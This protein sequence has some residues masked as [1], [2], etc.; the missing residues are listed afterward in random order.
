MNEE[1][2]GTCTVTWTWTW[3]LSHSTRFREHPDG[4]GCTAEWVALSAQRGGK[5]NG[6]CE[7]QET[8]GSLTNGKSAKVLVG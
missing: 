8:S 2:I 3:T 6:S 5:S 4:K 1:I 7:R